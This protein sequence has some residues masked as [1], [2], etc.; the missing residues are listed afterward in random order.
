[1]LCENNYYILF[2]YII[3]LFCIILYFLL[4]NGK[5]KLIMRKYFYMAIFWLFYKNIIKESTRTNNAL[6]TCTHDKNLSLRCKNLSICIIV[7]LD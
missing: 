1:M 4:S 3:I 6:N 2:N 5:K 7:K